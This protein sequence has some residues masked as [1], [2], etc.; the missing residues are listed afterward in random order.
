MI[1][2]LALMSLNKAPTIRL[3]E[4]SQQYLN[5]QPDEASRRAA[6]GELPFPVFRLSKSQRA[7]WVVTAAELGGYIDKC[8]AEAREQWE[9]V[10]P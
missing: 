7:P 10:Q 9:R 4:I 3:D 6:R 1:T 2:A 8:S 5:I